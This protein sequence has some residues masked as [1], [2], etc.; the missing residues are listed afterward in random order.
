[1][2]LILW[3]PGIRQ[4]RTSPQASKLSLFETTIHQLTEWLTRAE[5]KA[6]RLLKTAIFNFFS[7]VWSCSL[8]DIEAKFQHSVSIETEA[9]KVKCF[10]C[11]DSYLWRRQCS[12]F[13]H[14]YSTASFSFLLNQYKTS[15][16]T[17]TEEKPTLAILAVFP[18]LPMYI[19]KVWPRGKIQIKALP[20]SG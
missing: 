13:L 11:S 10:Q 4:S 6:T 15:L 8:E 2:S 16:S 9:F 14:C 3:E 7:Y 17:T 20:L 5:F 19:C 1:M 12:K 18:R